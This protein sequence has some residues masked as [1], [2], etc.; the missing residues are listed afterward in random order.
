MLEEHYR[1]STFLNIV[2]LYHDLQYQLAL[3]NL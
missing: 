3:L 2:S 1:K